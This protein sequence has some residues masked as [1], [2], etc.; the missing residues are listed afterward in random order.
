MIPNPL[1][2][3]PQAATDGTSLRLVFCDKGAK[4]DRELKTAARLEGRP[5]VP[6]GLYEV[7]MVA[8]EPAHCTPDKIILPDARTDIQWLQEASIRLDGLKIPD[9]S[10]IWLSATQ[11]KGIVCS[12]VGMEESRNF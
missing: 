5:K 1:F 8:G 2:Q 12:E 7:T 6:L 10:N 9:V 3:I 4:A 11:T